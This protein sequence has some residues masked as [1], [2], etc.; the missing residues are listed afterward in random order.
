MILNT[1]NERYREHC[2]LQL[3]EF[4]KKINDDDRFTV[5]SNSFYHNFGFFMGLNYFCRPKIADY[6]LENEELLKT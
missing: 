1:F 4:W 6:I 5:F 2:S 3:H